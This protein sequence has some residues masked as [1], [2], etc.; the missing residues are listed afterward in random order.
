MSKRRVQLFSLIAVSLFVLSIAG[1]ARLTSAAEETA[2]ANV[3]ANDAALKDLA[4]Y[5]QWTR[6]NEKAWPVF[7]SFIGG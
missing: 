7:N 6:V 1:F 2:K 3:F 5:R 4:S